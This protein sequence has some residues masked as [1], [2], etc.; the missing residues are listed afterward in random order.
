[1]SKYLTFGTR[2]SS[3]TDVK[4]EVKRRFKFLTVSVSIREGLKRREVR[5]VRTRDR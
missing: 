2:T 3:I 1:M 4:E 5:E